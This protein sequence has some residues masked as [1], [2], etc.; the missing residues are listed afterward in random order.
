MQKGR[1]EAVEKLR[2]LVNGN[3]G[4]KESVQMRYK[5]YALKTDKSL[6]TVNK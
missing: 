3:L 1:K 6:L 4:K 5:S 2:Q